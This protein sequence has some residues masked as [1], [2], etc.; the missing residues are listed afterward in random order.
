M[1]RIKGNVDEVRNALT[2]YEPDFPLKSFVELDIEEENFSASILA[3]VEEL[4]ASYD[5]HS[6][7]TIL[8]SKTTF[9]QGAKDTSD[10]FERGE[11]IEDMKPIDVFDKLLESQD[12]ASEQSEHLKSLFLELLEST[13]QND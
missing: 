13:Y 7:F 10:L 1:K 5:S 6:R 12:F 4:I 9:L 8:K 2:E 11:S 3:E